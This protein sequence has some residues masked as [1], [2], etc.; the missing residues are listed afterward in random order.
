MHF[1]NGLTVREL[2]EVI[3]TWSTEQD[4]FGEEPTV[5]IDHMNGTSSQIKTIWVLNNNDILFGE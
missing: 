3:S 4:S 5:W 1:P 2:K